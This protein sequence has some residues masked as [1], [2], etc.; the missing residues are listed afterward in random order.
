[1][2]KCSWA[3]HWCEIIWNNVRSPWTET[4]GICIAPKNGRFYLQKPLIVKL[5][6]IESN[7]AMAIQSSLN[8]LIRVQIL[9]FVT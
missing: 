5:G 6:V 2:S 4:E 1:M 8:K 7:Q 3:R 9:I